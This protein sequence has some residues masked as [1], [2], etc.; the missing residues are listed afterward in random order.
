MQR[1]PPTLLVVLLLVAGPA[2]PCSG[3]DA[4]VLPAPPS[5]ATPVCLYPPVGASAIHTSPSLV[6]S[7]VASARAYVIECADDSGFTGIIA[8]DTTDAETI[9][10]LRPHLPYA[11]TVYWRIAVLDTTRPPAWS[12][13]SHFATA[14]ALIS[15]PVRF[16]PTRRN[17]EAEGMFWLRVPVRGGVTIGGVRCGNPAYATETVVPWTTGEHDSIPMHVRFRPARYGIVHDT[18]VVITN[19]GNCSIPLVGDSPV[20]VVRAS[21]TV[22]ALGSAALTDT[23]TA[24]VCLRN[25]TQVN[26]AMIRRLRT[27]TPFFSI[28]SRAP[29]SIAPGDSLVLLARFHPRLPR[30]EIFGSFGDTLIVEYEG[31][32]ERVTL[33]AESP[34]PR[35][36][37]EVAMLDFGEIPALDTALTLLRITNSSIN[38][39]RI[40]SV[41]TRRRAFA[42]GRTRGSLRDSD[43]LSLPVRFS[44]GNHGWLHDTLVVYNNSWRGPLRIP[45]RAYVPYPQPEASVQSID[46]GVVPWNDTISFEVRVGNA[47]PSFL[48]VDSIRTRSRY[49]TCSKPSLP[50]AVTRGDSLRI[51]VHFRPDSARTFHDTLLIVTNGEERYVR[52]PITGSGSESGIGSR[53]E[54]RVGEYA[55]Y[56]NFPNPFSASTTFRYAVPVPSRVRLEL[57]STIGQSVAVVVDGVRETGHHDVVWHAEVPSGMYYCRFSAAP[58]SDPGGTFVGTRKLVIVR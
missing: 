35:P 3:Q 18:L 39:L 2:T 25:T 36:L 55:L 13:P 33:L 44:S 11:A 23:A 32:S 21:A 16:G 29:R 20:P 9:V 8:R 6:W 45:M 1:I 12:A 57:F 41:R 30:G 42:P 56:Q 28:A 46:F 4:G 52:I 26:D 27:R 58:L 17:E 50:F 5:N 53:S 15:S 43:T 47:S 14:P 10:R 51:R 19:H 54:S 40:D 22:C 34:P 37:A 31:G 48:R 49:F 7:G 24:R 38:T